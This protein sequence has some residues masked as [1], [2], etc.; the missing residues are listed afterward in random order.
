MLW[1]LMESM[2]RETPVLETAFPKRQYAISYAEH[3]RKARYAEQ[4]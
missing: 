4:F 3:A 2:V 1:K